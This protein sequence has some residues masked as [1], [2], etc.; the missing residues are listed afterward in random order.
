MVCCDNPNCTTEWFHFE[1]VGLHASPGGVWL[2]PICVMLPDGQVE[3][4]EEILRLGADGP[5]LP[6]PPPPPELPP[7]RGAPNA[8]ARHYPPSYR[9]GPP[10]SGAR[11]E[12]RCAEM[13]RD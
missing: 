12:P 10:G 2:C 6:P 9:H 3:P 8:Y 13:R 5:E 11:D 4:S 1:C 7:L